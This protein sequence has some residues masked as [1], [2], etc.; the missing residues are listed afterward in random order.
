MRDYVRLRYRLMP[1]LYSTAWQNHTTGL[2]IVRPL[3]FLD[4][5]DPHLQGYDEAFLFGDAFLVAP[6]QH[7]GQRAKTVY[8]PKGTWVHYWTEAVV[9]GGDSV[10]VDAPLARLPLF[11]RAGRIVPTRPVRLHTGA[12]PA[13]SLG[14][15]VYPHA[16]SPAAFTLYEDDGRSQAYASGA[17]ALTRI[18]QSMA[19]DALRL[20]VHPAQGTYDGLP[21]ERTLTAA[22]HRMATAPTAVH[23]N[24]TAVPLRSSRAAMAQRGGAFYDADRRILHVRWTGRT[25]SAQRLVARGVSLI[26]VTP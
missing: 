6:V 15:Q 7:E 17:Y 4:P 24:G 11:V 16:T 26:S 1:Y 9:A 22:I 21:A 2:P 13:D 18:E 5:S 3:F 10:T 19:G 14:L 25:D 20:T 8:L 23:V 12:Q